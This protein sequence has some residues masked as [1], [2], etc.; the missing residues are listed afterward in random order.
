MH[1]LAFILTLSLSGPWNSSGE[2]C[3]RAGGGA[4]VYAQALT[5]THPAPPPM[6]PDRGSPWLWANSH[7]VV[8]CVEGVLD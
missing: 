6:L 7:A 3:G 2:R 1:G 4:P 8:A 5:T